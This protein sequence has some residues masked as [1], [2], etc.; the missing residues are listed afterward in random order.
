MLELGKIPNPDA[1]QVSV[2]AGIFL[3]IG[4]VMRSAGSKRSSQVYAGPIT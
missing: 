1:R 4:P 2:R 3:G